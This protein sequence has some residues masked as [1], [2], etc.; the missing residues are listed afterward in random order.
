MLQQQHSESRNERISLQSSH[1]IQVNHSSQRSRQTFTTLAAQAKG[2]NRC[3]TAEVA[4]SIPAPN[5]MK[6]SPANRSCNTITLRQQIVGIWVAPIC[7]T[8][9]SRRRK[10]VND[11]LFEVIIKFLSLASKKHLPHTTSTVLRYY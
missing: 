11:Y 4:S 2:R 8:R 10:D 7:M 9:L 5:S 1:T 3:G 6:R